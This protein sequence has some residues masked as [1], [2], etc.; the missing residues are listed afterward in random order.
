MMIEDFK[1]VA[2]VIP[3]K[4]AEAFAALIRIEDR[5]KALEKELEQKAEAILKARAVLTMP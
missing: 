2:G 3:F 4:E 1:T 5:M